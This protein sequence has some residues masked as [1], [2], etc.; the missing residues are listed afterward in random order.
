MA[1]GKNPKNLTKK[2]KKKT[3][4]PFLKKDWYDIRA[5]IM[6]DV[7][8]VGKTPVTRT[9][10]TKI[11]SE[12][13]KGRVFEINLADMKKDDEGYRKI[14]LIGEEVQG[15]NVLTNFYGMDFTRD[16]LCSLL[17]KWQTLIE[18]NVDIK[19]S[20]GYT[21]RMFC[22]AFTKRTA[23]QVR[24][25]SYAQSA[26]ARAIRA[27]MVE[28]M[29][30]E[31]SK[32]DLKDLVVKFLPEAIGKEIEKACRSI[33]PLQNVFIRKVKI[34][35]QPKFDLAKLMEVHGEGKGASLA[36]TVARADEGQVEA[37][38]GSGGRY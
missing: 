7:R 27:K 20:D 35:K 14:K 24:K 17:K 36:P 34:L 12:A 26:Q 21:V 18:A 2:G 11:A 32:C 38:A 1:K 29:V 15:T 37:A 28:I 31:A 10:G 33:Y 19:T 22:I 5:P 30:S 6:F 25:T 13:L 8:N 4:D 3:A 9:H 16:K 23:G